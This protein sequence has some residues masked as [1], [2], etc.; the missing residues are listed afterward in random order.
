MSST[1]NRPRP[2]VDRVSYQWSACK[3]PLVVMVYWKL[4]HSVIHIPSLVM[5]TSRGVSGSLHLWAVRSGTMVAQP[6][7]LHGCL[8][9]CLILVFHPSSIYRYG[10]RGRRNKST[11]INFSGRISIPLM[12]T[13]HWGIAAL[14]NHKPRVKVSS[15]NAVYHTKPAINHNSRPL[16]GMYPGYAD[17]SITINKKKSKQ[18]TK[19]FCAPLRRCV[20]N[21]RPPEGLMVAPL[22]S[23]VTPRPFKPCVCWW[24]PW[25]PL[26]AYRLELARK[27]TD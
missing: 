1:G 10:V 18:N 14:S 4:F 16:T 8:H 27:A 2:W 7:T 11:C 26:K 21:A 15:A 12:F 3:L 6:G 19:K 24:L 5:G 17:C 25:R 13:L 9:D 22:G 20:S 23:C